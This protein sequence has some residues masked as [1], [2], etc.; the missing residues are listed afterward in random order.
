MALFSWTL[1]SIANIA[2]ELPSTS[3]IKWL[4][5]YMIQTIAH[6]CNIIHADSS[7]MSR[8]MLT[9]DPCTDTWHAHADGALHHCWY[10]QRITVSST[11]DLT[12]H[13]IGKCTAE[14]CGVLSYRLLCVCHYHS[15]MPQ[16]VSVYSGVQTVSQAQHPSLADNAFQHQPQHL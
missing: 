14:S 13:T 6:L 12:L 11:P 3:L 9:L 10:R 7:Y 15:E 16:I 1:S 2:W 5:I 4:P 8:H